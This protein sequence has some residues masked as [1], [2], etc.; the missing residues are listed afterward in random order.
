[1]G[2]GSVNREVVRE[3]G[4]RCAEQRLATVDATIIKSRKQEALRAYE[5][6][7]CYQPMLLV[8]RK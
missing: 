7:R 8:W 1:M 5:G 6:E 4:R 2:W 3:V